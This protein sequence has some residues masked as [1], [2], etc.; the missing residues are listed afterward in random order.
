MVMSPSR[1]TANQGW[2]RSDAWVVNSLFKVFNYPKAAVQTDLVA[3]LCFQV[4]VIS[5]CHRAEA[6]IHWEN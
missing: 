2:Q 5:Q 1:T 4:N 6:V 3:F